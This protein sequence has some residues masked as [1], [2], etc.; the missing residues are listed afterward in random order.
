[1]KVFVCLAITAIALSSSLAAQ[2]ST[3][4][5]PDHSKQVNG[6]LRTIQPVPQTLQE[7]LLLFAGS[8]ANDHTLLTLNNNHVKNLD[9]AATIYTANGQETDLRYFTFYLGRAALSTW[10]ICY[11]PR[12]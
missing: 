4:P 7:V 1:M 9:V 3:N 8:H 5:L 11:V 10:K 2:N 12:V 6:S